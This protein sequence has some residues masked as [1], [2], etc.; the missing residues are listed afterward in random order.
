MIILKHWNWQ[1]YLFGT[2]LVTAIASH[3]AKATFQ[4]CL[5]R[6]KRQ[7]I[8]NLVLLVVLEILVRFVINCAALYHRWVN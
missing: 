6:L 3:L 7:M 1:V 4:E 2:I 5:G 8:I